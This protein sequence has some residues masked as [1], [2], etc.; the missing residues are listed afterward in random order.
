MIRPLVIGIVGLLAGA[1]LTVGFQTLRPP[2]A[3]ITP[4][5][6]QDAGELAGL[7]ACEQVEVLKSQ[8]PEL[9]ANLTDAKADLADAESS[10][11]KVTGLPVP[12]SGEPP[13]PRESLTSSLEKFGGTLLALDCSEDPCIHASLFVG[14]DADADGFLAEGP[15]QNYQRVSSLSGNNAENVPHQ[16]VVRTIDGPSDDTANATRIEYRIGQL[17]STGVKRITFE[18]L[19]PAK[20]ELGWKLTEEAGPAEAEPAEEAQPDDGAPE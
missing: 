12:W 18:P 11:R 6:G 10:A 1:G 9:Q 17:F 3:E 8:L 13:N 7:D 16:I 5:A 19:D 15:P 14:P 4:P 2:A 20:P